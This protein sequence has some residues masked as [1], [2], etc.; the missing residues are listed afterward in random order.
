MTIFRLAVASV[1]L[2]TA[3]AESV[4]PDETPAKDGGPYNK[5]DP[6]VDPLAQPKREAALEPGVWTAQIIGGQQA[7]SFGDPQRP[8]LSLLCDDREGLVL[9]RRAG[10]E[11]RPSLLRLK[12][13]TESSRL[14]QNPIAGE[15]TIFKIAIPASSSL[16][17]NFQSSEVL[18]IE[19][20]GQ[21][22]RLIPVNGLVRNFVESCPTGS[23]RG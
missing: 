14:A 21:A 18:Q 19:V 2:T 1:L 8:N 22:P 7:L 10:P 17:D 5:I 4:P 6:V 11:E 9:Q 12:I 20:G 23:T 3:C 15:P 16:I 13:G